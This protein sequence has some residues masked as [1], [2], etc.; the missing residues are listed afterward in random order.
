MT[1]TP[2]SSTK[3]GDHSQ[4]SKK[5]KIV[6]KGMS[7][8]MIQE[9]AINQGQTKYRGTQLFEWMYRH[10]IQK[11]NKMTNI[12][13]S[14]RKFLEENCDLMTLEIDK[15]TEEISEPTCKILFKT[16]D[17]HF[18]E[19][20]SM[21]DRKRHTVCLSSQIGC[22]LGC[23]F[24]ATATMGLIRNLTAGEIVDQLIW[25]RNLVDEPVTNIVFMGMGEP[26]LNYNRVMQAADIFHHERGFNLAS[27][28]ITISTAGIVPKISQFI[29]EKRRYK[30]AISL[31]APDNL[32]RNQI[33]PI[34][35]EWNIK[36]IVATGKLFSNQPRREVMFEYVLIKGVNDR[37]KDAIKLGRL[38][39]GINCKLNIIPYNEFN[40]KYHRPS[41]SEIEKFMQILYDQQGK[42][43]VLIRWSKG[44]NISAACGQ[45]ATN[46]IGKQVI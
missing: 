20:V 1:F 4:P 38:L 11:T 34:N 9:W 3:T 43:R 10:G 12:S 42:C 5:A 29:T 39:K 45:L 37:E 35:E 15:I 6:L 26:F 2:N 16:R 40:G 21:L 7:L 27:S 14:F 13:G 44:K 33:M 31:N 41:D 19:T 32:V 46:N 28:R 36:N 17:N 8:E 30:L 22:S 24:C 25:V 18:I 23:T